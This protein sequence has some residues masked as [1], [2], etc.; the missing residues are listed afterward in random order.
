ML[1]IEVSDSTLH[2]DQDEKARLYAAAGIADYWVVN[3]PDE[4][5]EVRREPTAIG[6]ISTVV[7]QPGE[8]VRPLNVSNI[9]LNVKTL[10]DEIGG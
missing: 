4:C 1:V 7:Y 5:L 9:V 10:F 8:Q 2:F 6:Y 3:I